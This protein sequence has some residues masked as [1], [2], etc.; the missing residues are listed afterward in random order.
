M[1]IF[2]L[3]WL[4]D[5]RTS[6]WTAREYFLISWGYGVIL[7]SDDWIRLLVPLFWGDAEIAPKFDGAL[8]WHI[9]HF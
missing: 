3:Y 2:F 9:T 1:F 6:E 8:I 5:F 4:L 7:I